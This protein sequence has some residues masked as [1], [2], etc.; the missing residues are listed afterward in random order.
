MS[1][2]IQR[3]ARRYRA[4]AAA[5]ERTEQSIDGWN[6]GQRDIEVL[7]VESTEFGRTAALRLLCRPTP[8]QA[9]RRHETGH[10]RVHD[11]DRLLAALAEVRRRLVNAP[12]A[13][14]VRAGSVFRRQHDE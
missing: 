9:Y 7:F 5:V 2:Y 4:D 3:M 14:D 11:V 13:P 12:R 8:G 6:L 1:D 10:L